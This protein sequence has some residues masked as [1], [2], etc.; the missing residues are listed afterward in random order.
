[1]AA[2]V[3]HAE[4]T[5]ELKDHAGVMEAGIADRVDRAESFYRKEREA[6]SGASTLM[7][8]VSLRS[9]IPASE[10]LQIVQKC[11][12]DPLEL[13]RTFGE[14]Q[15]SLGIP[16]GPSADADRQVAKQIMNFVDFYRKNSPPGPDGGPSNETGRQFEAFREKT[17]DEGRAE[18]AAGKALVNG[19]RVRGTFA[20][21]DCMRAGFGSRH[22]A[23]EILKRQVPFAIP[24]E[25]AGR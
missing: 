2:G 16:E 15:I 4:W 19:V 21:L 22:F 13:G 9:R 7:V 20:Q 25:I 5:R 14:T 17:L 23:T 8:L 24:L 3:V 18:A 6:S 10:V 11:G 1:M 12:A